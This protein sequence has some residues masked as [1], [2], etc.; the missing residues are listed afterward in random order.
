MQFI[1]PKTGKPAVSLPHFPTKFQS[2]IFRA[3]EY[4]PAGKI[5]QILN[6]TE[7]NVRLAAAQMGLPDREPDKLW[8]TQGY[9]TIIKRMWHILPYEQLL[10]LLEMDEQTLAITLRED[11]F[12]DI[13]LGDKPVCEKVVWRELTAQ[14]KKQTEEIRKTLSTLDFSGVQPFDFH[15]EVPQISAAG[16]ALFDTRMI[17][18]F[19]GLYQHAF[20]VDSRV[21][22]PD[23][24]LEAYSKLGINAVWTQGILFQLTEFPFAPAISNGWQQRIDRMKD[25][26]DRLEKYGMKL[27]LYLNEP[28]SMPSDFYKDY[29]HLK[30][31]VRAEE[32][33]CLCVST[34]QVQEYLT[35]AIETLCRAVPNIGG[36]FTITRSENPTNCY[37]HSEPNSTVKPCNCP[38][39]SRRPVAD[40]IHD[41]IA[42]FRN[43][44]DRV[45]PKIK[46]FAW[47]W[48][49][50]EH[51]LEIIAKLPER[52]ILLS[53]S[54]L[55]V[56]YEIG[57]VKGAV[58]DYSMSIIGPGERATREWKAARERGLETGAKVQVN[59][60]WEAS[61]V[62]AL[63]VYEA[64][65][66][67]IRGVQ[68]TGVSHLLLSWTLGGYPSR[69]VAH[70]AKFFYESSQMEE[71][72]EIT[73]AAR[74]FSEAF[75]EYP[76]HISSVYHGPHNAGPSSMLF[77]GK[78]GYQATMTCF[79]Y[80]DVDCWRSI[81]PVDIYEQQFAKLCSR[82]ERGLEMLRDVPPCETTVMAHAA[83]CL[84]K[85]SLDQIRFYRAREIGDRETMLSCA[86]EEEKTARK[87]LELM[88]MDA[89]IGYEA[90]NHYYFS[91]GQ[92][93]EK[94]VNCQY[95]IRQ[96]TRL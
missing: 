88:N 46:V 10:Q 71:A 94:I 52:V 54:E 67:H 30:G 53:Q 27:F 64:I 19:S 60:T 50:N 17:Y 42:C 33:I 61:T 23:S 69:S 76:F 89:S 32:K 81:Y 90:A 70:A 51:N 49:W 59:T 44:A 1:L 7:D 73:N 77:L 68:Q 45:D 87:M 14:E 84:F 63:P 13:K 93:A 82:W 5:A 86:R 41:T 35:N 39:C 85:S 66:E 95:V 40:V 38:R 25:F 26:A 78:T 48:G 8:M 15:Y 24:M 92:I 22:C 96:L 74:V 21:F 57:G 16:E 37:S 34:P 9:I 72:P 56:P 31:H 2:F 28:R 3:H 47:S 83:Y 12:L 55:G 75:R 79:A 20:D 11:D 58:L 62:P 4:V 80:D 65:E 43:G 36:F 6:T 18:A 91:K 29:P